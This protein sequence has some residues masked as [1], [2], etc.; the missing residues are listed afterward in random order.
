M[1]VAIRSLGSVLSDELHCVFTTFSPSYNAITWA[2]FIS[3]SLTTIWAAGGATPNAIPGPEQASAVFDAF[4]SYSLEFAFFPDFAGNT[5]APN[6]FS[7]NLLA[8]LGELQ[9]VRPYIRVGGNTQD[10]A[11]YDESLPYAVNG[12]YD[13]ERSKDYPT[14]IHIG[15]SYFESYGTFADTKFTHGFN[16]GLGANRS[17][18]WET[19]KATVPLACKAIGKDNLD[20]WE[21][22]NEPDLFST[23]AQGPVRP[24][25]WNESIYVEQWLN[26]T[27]EIADILAEACPDFPK[28]VFMAPSNA[29]TANRLRAPAQ[30]AAGL[31]AD[32]NIATFSTHNYISGAESPGVTLQGTLMNHT[33]T[34]QSVQAHVREYANMT[35][36]FDDVPPHILGEH[37]SLYN[38]GKPGLSNSFGA[39]L[40]GIDF[41]LYAASQ[42]IKRNHMHMGTDY[43]YQSW[44]PVN[45]DTTAIGTKAPYY[46]NIA[47]AA[48]LAPPKSSDPVSVVHIPL[49]GDNEQ[50]AAYA[51]YHG[52]TLARLI[53]I[54]MQAYNSTINGTGTTPDPNPKSRKDF[55]YSFEVPWDGGLANVRRLRANG[56][57]A[58]TG[59]TWDGWSYNYELDEGKPVKLDNVTVEEYALVS[60]GQVLFTALASEAV[61]I[62]PD[63]G[64]KKRS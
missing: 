3:Q 7:D 54:N 43:R 33:R 52:D 57:D 53:V 11:L 5:S 62:S 10:Y 9:G 2:K 64:C 42:G 17:E 18:G 14:T 27:R 63:G 44:Q 25:S 58:I 41:N 22:G 55:G 1:S 30:W 12:T 40:W 28:P 34:V 26:G 59:I 56:S 35:D 24:S 32:E 23:S 19:L 8:N 51:A 29:G 49:E 31:N 45:T 38:Q 39:A 6:T 16:L 4:V 21:Y 15:S 48:F 37:N 13:F 46:G 36:R 61:I 50:S 47:I 20:V 60:G